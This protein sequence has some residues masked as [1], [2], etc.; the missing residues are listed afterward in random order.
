MS[1]GGHGT[2]AWGER[3]VGLPS[4]EWGDDLDV[5]DEP[6]GPNVI[7]D[8]PGEP[9]RWGMDGEPHVLDPKI[10]QAQE[11]PLEVQQKLFSGFAGHLLAHQTQD[12]QPRWSGENDKQW[13]YNLAIW[14][15]WADEERARSRDPRGP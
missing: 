4:V 3:H 11:E 15:G 13:L 5:T 9:P 7:L 10:V 8:P 6:L 1:G 14:F 12:L 2:P